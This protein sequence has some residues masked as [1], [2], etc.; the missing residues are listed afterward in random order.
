MTH[1]TMSQFFFQPVLALDV[2]LS[3]LKLLLFFSSLWLIFLILIQRGKGGGLTAAFGGGGGDSAFGAKAGDAFTKITIISALVWIT[4]CMIT[5]ARYNPPETAGNRFSDP[6]PAVE[7]DDADS[8]SASLG[9]PTIG[10]PADAEGVETGDAES[11]DASTEGSET[12]AA[13]N[14][15]GATDGDADAA[16][17]AEESQQ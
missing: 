5:I 1:E 16:G 15:G 10:D 3:L 6:P 2:G 4:L 17:S 7:T 8:S 14:G 11:S 13:D 12:P 9:G